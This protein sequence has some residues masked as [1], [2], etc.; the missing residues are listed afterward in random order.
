PADHWHARVP[1]GD[2]ASHV[3]EIPAVSAD[4][5]V[6]SAHACECI[7]AACERRHRMPATHTLGQHE[8]AG[9]TRRPDYRNLEIRFPLIRYTCV[10]P[11][12][13][14]C[15]N[16]TRIWGHVRRDFRFG[17]FYTSPQPHPRIPGQRG[18]KTRQIDSAYHTF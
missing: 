6:E 5:G 9:T 7:R 13:E 17:E 10:E 2:G 14:Y 11:G 4:H 1:P 18:G 3:F 16:R 8:S 12:H 15:H